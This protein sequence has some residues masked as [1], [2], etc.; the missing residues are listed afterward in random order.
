MV[1]NAAQA[2]PTADILALSDP[3]DHLA[4][5]QISD[6]LGEPQ[7][8]ADV[9]T[10]TDQFNLAGQTLDIV[11]SRLVCERAKAVLVP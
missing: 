11:R 3:E 10:V 6:L 2:L 4:C 1:C 7:F 5:Y 9:E 8:A